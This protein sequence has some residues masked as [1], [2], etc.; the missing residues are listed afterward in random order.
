M[1]KTNPP[2]LLDLDETLAD[3]ENLEDLCA[4]RPLR[5]TEIFQPN[6]FYGIDNILKTYAGLPRCY[7]LKAVVPHGIYLS[8]TYV[9]DAEQTASLP[10]VFCPPLRQQ[11]YIDQIK[12]FVV[13]SAAPFLYVKELL[14]DYPH[15]KRQGT[16]FFL[17]HST[18]YMTTKADFEQLAEQLSSLESEYQPVTVCIYWKDYLLGHH[19]PFQNRG[20]RIISAGHIFDSHFL[21]RLYHLCSQY[22][23]SCSNNIGSHLFYSVKAGCSF[24][25]IE[26]DYTYNVIPNSFGIKTEPRFIETETEFKELFRQPHRI[27]TEK[28][29]NIIDDYLGITF[30]QSQQGLLNQIILAE[31]L[32]K[33]GF[34]KCNGIKLDNPYFFQRLE[35]LPSRIVGKGKRWFAMLHIL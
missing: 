23:Y 31:A 18:H 17:S 29:Q 15:P 11:I 20:M 33:V 12:K 3:Q 2:L 6:A 25:F 30:F 10:M 28:Q 35:K 22:H 19:I 4:D 34:V 32:D 9:W 7:A 5:T 21:F 1:Y 24:F 27:M 14:K 8:K 16:I 26:G 13:P